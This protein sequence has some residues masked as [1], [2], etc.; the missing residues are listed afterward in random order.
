[1]TTGTLVTILVDLIGEVL[2]CHDPESQMRE[3]IG[4]A[5]E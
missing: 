3:E 2:I 4:D 1:M 5:R